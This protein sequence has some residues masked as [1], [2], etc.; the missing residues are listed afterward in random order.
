MRFRVYVEI[1]EDF[2]FV[3]RRRIEGDATKL[4]RREWTRDGLTL[5]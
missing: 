2:V 3:M 1:E 5:K 4:I